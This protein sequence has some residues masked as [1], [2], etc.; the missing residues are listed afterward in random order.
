MSLGFAN[1]LCFFLINTL[2]VLHLQNVKNDR[3]VETS[4]AA[5]KN[6]HEKLKLKLSEN[7]NNDKE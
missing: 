5:V 3:L 4:R 7:G 6:N 2:S 1:I